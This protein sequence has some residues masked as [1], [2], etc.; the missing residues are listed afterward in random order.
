MTSLF[1]EPSG[2]YRAASQSIPNRPSS[3]GVKSSP[4]TPAAASAAGFGD[5][6]PH[7]TGSGHGGEGFIRFTGFPERKKQYGELSCDGHDGPLLGL[8][9][10]PSWAR[11]SPCSRS[12]L[13]GPEG[14]QNMLR[15]CSPAGVSGIG[16]R[17]WKCV[18]VYQS[19]PFWS[20]FG[21]FQPFDPSFHLLK[22]VNYPFLAVSFPWH[23]LSFLREPLPSE[24]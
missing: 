16:P 10:S 24:N 6:E 18:I 20:R 9:C 5:A 15:G 11:R 14:S 4:R 7:H 3:V 13:S 21:H 8:G 17:I 19:L 12:A 22:S 23:F 2:Y 1:A